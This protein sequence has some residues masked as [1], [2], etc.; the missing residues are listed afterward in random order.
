MVVSLGI[1]SCGALV[2]WWVGEGE[3]SSGKIVLH[4]FLGLVWDTLRLVVVPW[5]V[6]GGEGSSDR[7]IL[8]RHFLWHR[9]PHTTYQL[10]PEPL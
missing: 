7:V 2:L 5:W 6:G 4:L 3:G 1:A 8:T 10:L 9:K